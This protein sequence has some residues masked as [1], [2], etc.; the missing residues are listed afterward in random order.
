MHDEVAVFLYKN[1]TLVSMRTM[2]HLGTVLEVRS[3]LPNEHN[4]KNSHNEH[5]A[6]TIFFFLFNIKDRVRIADLIQYNLTLIFDFSVFFS[7]FHLLI[8]CIKLSFL[9]LMFLFSSCLQLFSL[10]E[11]STTGPRDR[12]THL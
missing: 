10:Y 1:L 4:S 2:T 9:G 8:S 11:K 7:F 6:A 12:Y 3:S 5:K